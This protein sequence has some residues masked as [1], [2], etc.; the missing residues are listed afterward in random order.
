MPDLMNSSMLIY[1][2]PGIGKSTFAD[3][4]D[5]TLFADC[6]GGLKWLDSPNRVPIDSWRTFKTLVDDLAAGKPIKCAD[7]KMLK[8]KHVTTDTVDILWIL[9]TQYICKKHG[10]EHPADES[11]GK[12]FQVL[13]YEFQSVL[14]KLNVHQ[15]L[16][17]I[18][19]SHSKV[20]EQRGRGNATTKKIVPSIPGSACAVILPMVDIIAYAGQDIVDNTI[21]SDR[22]LLTHPQEDL[23]AKDRTGR[24]PRLL[25]LDPQ[26]LHDALRG[27]ARV[28]NRKQPAKTTSTGGAPSPAKK[29]LVGRK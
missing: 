12:G 29:K 17:K 28:I 14:A 2:P 16:G 27:K 8:P 13:R 21:M 1:G 7:G 18:Y 23:E 4:F 25:P 11:F 5:D 9:C 26:A 15:S 10:F 6:E 22:A 3:G 20:M 19:I 24:L